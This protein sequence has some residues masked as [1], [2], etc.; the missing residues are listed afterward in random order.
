M[1]NILVDTCFWYALYDKKDEFHTI[2]NEI[3]EYLSLGN[4]IIIPFPTLYETMNTSFSKDKRGLEAFKIL[5][6]RNNFIILDDSDYKSNALEITF[7]SSLVKNRPLS[8]V[9]TVIREILYD[10]KIKINYL[11]TFN[12]KDFYDVCNKKGIQIWDK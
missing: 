1:N 7:K 8:L 12:V 10:D 4:N 2:A 9:D 5:L 3:F 11:I 6:D